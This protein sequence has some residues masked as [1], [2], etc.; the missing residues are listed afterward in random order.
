M[1]ASKVDLK[2][3]EIRKK[4]S[5]KVLKIDNRRLEKKSK[6]RLES[7]TRKW[8]KSTIYDRKIPLN[9]KAIPIR[10]WKLMKKCIVVG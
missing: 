7:R 4:L 1:T 3:P 8:K 9:W 2:L 5:K 10:N 6:Y